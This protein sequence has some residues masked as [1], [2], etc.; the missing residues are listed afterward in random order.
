MRKPKGAQNWTQ[1]SEQAGSHKDGEAESEKKGRRTGGR[2]VK[3][4]PLVVT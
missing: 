2:V 4:H 3:D 1:V